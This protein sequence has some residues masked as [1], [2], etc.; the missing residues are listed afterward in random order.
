MGL[1]GTNLIL[2][3][4][5]LFLVLV[6]ISQ[7]PCQAPARGGGVPRMT[8]LSAEQKEAIAQ[9]SG[10]SEMNEDDTSFI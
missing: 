6:W 10:P 1:W 3:Q 9:M 8:K 5:L 4:S 2:I 7:N